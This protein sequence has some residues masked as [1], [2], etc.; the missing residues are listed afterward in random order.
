MPRGIKRVAA[1]PAIQTL[2]AQVMPEVSVA[3][4]VEPVQE[5]PAVAAEVPRNTAAPVRR[6]R[7]VFNGSEGKLKVNGTIPGYHLHILNDEGNRITNALDN[8]YEFVAPGEIDGVT[9]NVVSRNGDLG[10]SKIRFLVGRQEKGDAMY[11]YLMKIRLE[12]YDEDQR[13]TQAKN[14]KIDQAIRK[15]QVNGPVANSYIPTG[16]IKISSPPPS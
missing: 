6:K 9:E 13:E 3:P 16:G 7:N 10:D 12:W 1:A 2:A 5:A 14:D 8:G 15:G 11:G 4:V